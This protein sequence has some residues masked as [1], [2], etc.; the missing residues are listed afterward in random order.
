MVEDTPKLES[1]LEPVPGVRIG[2]AA[3]GI[4]YAGRPDVMMAGFEAGTT[5]AGVLTTSTTAAAPVRWTRDLLARGAPPG[6]LVVGAG[7]ANCFTGKR[8]DEAVAYT[9][10]QAGDLLGCDADNVYIA[11]TGK[12][13][14]QIDLEKMGAA[15]RTAHAAL[16]PDNWDQAAAAIMTTDRYP[17]PG[18]VDAAI[19]GVPVALQGM[20][21]GSTMIAPSMATTL[22]FLFTDARIPADI[23]QAALR[24]ATAD[25]YNMI[26]VDNTQSTNDT[27]LLFATGTGADHPEVQDI[28]DPAFHD[29]RVKLRDLL[30]GL[31]LMIVEDGRKDGTLIRI[32]VNGAETV[33]AARRIAATVRESRMIHRMV[34]R[35][36]MLAL[37]RFVAAIGMAAEKV[38]QDKLD[39]RI[40]GVQTMRDGEFTDGSMVAK[41]AVLV[42]DKLDVSVDVGVGEGRATAYTVAV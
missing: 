34:L 22:S 31:A 4:G 8:G 40:G 21:K 16:S 14:V 25:T 26:S 19:G 2:T 18:R 9:A 42:D 7:N 35:D 1:A 30:A 6:G 15:I 36:D 11:S 17:K 13:G 27:I 32:R 12:I 38:D 33:E 20:T 29:F 28:A 5:V 3:S 37:G 10:G 41:S 23:L 39:L 24:E